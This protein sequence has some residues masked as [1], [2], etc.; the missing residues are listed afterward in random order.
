MLTDTFAQTLKLAIV[1]GAFII[2]TGC[3]APPT[4]E[5]VVQ[6]EQ[7]TGPVPRYSLAELPAPDHW[8]K[9]T[10]NGFDA[11]FTHVNVLPG[12][13]P[14]EFELRS[15]AYL[16]LFL[17]GTKTTIIII[18][19]DWVA[20]NLRLKRFRYDY[21]IDG[22]KSSVDGKV[23]D[24]VLRANITDKSGTTEQIESLQ[25][26]LYPG[27]ASFLYPVINGLELGKG[28]SYLTYDGEA[29]EVKTVVQRVAAYGT[30]DR[31]ESRA[32]K[33]LSNVGG[34]ASQIWIDE[35]GRA[36]LEVSMKGLFLSEMVEPI[37]AR[38]N[39]VR[40]AFNHKPFYTDF[41]T[42]HPVG[43]ID[44]QSRVKALRVDITGFGDEWVL[45]NNDSQRCW[46]EADVYACQI[47]SVPAN[48][49]MSDIEDLDD[50]MLLSSAS[51]TSDDPGVIA[52]AEAIA[53]ESDEGGLALLQSLTEWISRRVRHG[54]D[55]VQSALDVLAGNRKSAPLG[56]TYLY[57][58]MARALG[59]PTRIANGLVYSQDDQGF[60]YHSWAESW[61]DG[62]WH[63]VDPA[64]GGLLVD[65]THIK[66]AQAD[67]IAELQAFSDVIG[68]IQVHVLAY[69]N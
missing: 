66:L 37:E 22:E 35:Q 57:A 2:V 60:I 4:F 21:S 25:R 40:A 7:V 26:A 69:D 14:E 46:R 3:A 17:L 20:P 6:E 65:A 62:F 16:Q 1:C 15:E 27:R 38:T 67:T 59:I 61:V 11:G 48:P 8:T 33:V 34:A 36:Q 42:V 13:H 29:R 54:T 63:R 45:P 51:I 9:L 49:S 10:L 30:S 41:T 43:L 53:A 12:T 39:L 58:S 19:S 52:I 5:E 68:R 23:D 28:Y 18:S 64:F 47:V 32:F 31:I 56:R 44:T 55:P 50:E 24:H